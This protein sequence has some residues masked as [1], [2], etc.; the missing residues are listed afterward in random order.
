MLEF[1]LTDSGQRSVLAKLVA[2]E[3]IGGGTVAAGGRTDLSRGA[4]CMDRLE[5]LR[6]WPG[7]VQNHEGEKRPCS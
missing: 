7:S 2:S 3:R 4:F 5:G 1:G 6:A